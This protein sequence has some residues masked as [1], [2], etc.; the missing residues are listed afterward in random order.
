MV[1]KLL[2]IIL[3]AGKLN[4]F[5]S[6]LASTLSRAMEYEV[7]RAGIGGAFGGAGVGSAGGDRGGGDTSGGVDGGGGEGTGRGNDGGMACS[8]RA[9]TSISAM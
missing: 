1:S 3:L 2:S 4:G 5:Q 9:Y 7:S 8:G 6:R